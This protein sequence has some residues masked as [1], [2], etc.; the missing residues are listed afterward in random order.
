M[1][2]DTFQK[3]LEINLVYIFIFNYERLESKN[4]NI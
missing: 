4:K 3:Y 2:D 1:D